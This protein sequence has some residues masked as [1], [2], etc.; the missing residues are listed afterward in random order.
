MTYMIY[1]LIEYTLHNSLVTLVC[2][3]PCDILLRNR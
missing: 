1:I 2:V 3:S